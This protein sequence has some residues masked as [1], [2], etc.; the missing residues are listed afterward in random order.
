MPPFF[1]S[2]TQ[3]KK[4]DFDQLDSVS[5]DLGV[6]DRE[7][8][9]GGANKLDDA[10]TMPMS[11]TAQGRFLSVYEAVRWI[12]S[13][14]RLVRGQRLRIDTRAVAARN[15]SMTLEQV[16]SDPS[17]P[18]RVFAR[19]RVT[20]VWVGVDRRPARIPDAV[21]QALGVGR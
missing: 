8:T 9:T 7:I 10:S 13:L 19:A 16:A 11:V 6:T 12:E 1:S 20:V 14:P 18:E 2:L 15:T 21:R 17:A 4:I 3:A 5:R